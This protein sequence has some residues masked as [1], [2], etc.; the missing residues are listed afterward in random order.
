MQTAETEMLAQKISFS[1]EDFKIEVMEKAPPGERRALHEAIEIKYFYEDR[2]ALMINSELIIA[3]AGDITVVNPYEVHT[4]VSIDK[5]GGR[6]YLI[7]VDLDFLGRILPR[8]MDLR[9]FFFAEHKRIKN[10]IR[11]DRRLQDILRHLIEETAGQKKHYRHVVQSLVTEL[12]ALL[13]RDHV[14]E[15]EA[16]KSEDDRVK[17]VELIAPALARMHTDYARHLTVEELA[18]LCRVTKYHFCRVFRRAMGV[19]AVQYLTSYRIDLAEAMLRDAGRSI[20]EVA[21]ACGFEDESY[22]YRCYKKYKG[23]SPKAERKKK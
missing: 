3:H 10:L 4:T 15:G 20:R 9:Q 7:M 11:G 5:Y 17:Y 16:E 2:S 21:F 19:T 13:L 18:A 14:D 1:D 8:E 22:F 12:F 6:Y 23:R